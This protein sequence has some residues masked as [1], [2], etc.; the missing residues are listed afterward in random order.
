MQ[1]AVQANRAISVQSP[2]G[3]DALLLAG[4]TGREAI[5]QIFK[6]E[7]D[8]VAANNTPVPFEKLLGQKLTV[9]TALPS[10]KKRF[11][12]GIVSRM[13]E[14]ARG[15]EFT[16][17]WVEI[18]PQFWLLTK[19]FQSRI[20][21]H[22]TVPEILKQVMADLDVSFEVMGTFHPRDYTVQYRETDFDFA[23]R[24]ME[25]EGIFYFFKH[26][27]TGHKMVVAN[28]AASHPELPEQSKIFYEEILGGAR[29]EDRITE[30]ERIQEVRSSKVTLWDNCF[31]LPGQHLEADKSVQTEATV[32]KISQKLRIAANDKSEIYEYPGDYAKRFDGVDRGGTAKPNDLSLIFQDNKRTA[33][34]R[35]QQETAPGVTI[36]GTGT[37]RQMVC[38]H[39][40][41]LDRH[42]NANGQYLITSVDHTVQMSGNFRSGGGGDAKVLINFTCIPFNVPYRPQRK[43]ERPLIYGT[44]TAVVVGP[45]GQE[46]FTDEYGRVKVQFH[47]DREGKKNPDSSCWVRV[48]QLWA[49]KRWG[50]SFWPRIGQEVVVA[51][52]NGD[53]DQPIIVGSVYNAEQMPPYLGPGPDPK[54]KSDRK[55][56]GIK[57]C[58]TPGGGG[59]NE[60]RFDDTKGKEQV[61]LHAQ[62]QKDERVGGDS[63]ESVGNDRHLIVHANQLEHVLANKNLTVDGDQFEFIAGSEAKTVNVNQDL[64]VMGSKMETIDGDVGFHCYGHVYETIDSFKHVVTGDS[65]EQKVDGR[66]TVE[67]TRSIDLKAA[68]KIVLESDVCV[69]LK[70]G[71]SYVQI[72]PDGVDIFGPAVWI[73]SGGNEAASCEACGA[74]PAGDAKDADPA[75]P[76]EADG[77]VTGFPSAKDAQP[78]PASNAAAGKKDK[79]KGKGGTKEHES[80]TEIVQ[81]VGGLEPLPP[82][83]VPRQ[84]KSSEPQIPASGGI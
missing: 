53:P 19:R 10:G 44:Q 84:P 40:F 48:A 15:G 38:G 36:Q 29:A 52:E 35:M 63:L 80:P 59:F 42:H 3:K 39:R 17:Y 64:A 55:V 62:T 34:I 4:F 77:A 66:F 6:F 49:G 74:S 9:E 8:L 1:L 13:G 33:E 30:W 50:A 27:A 16:Q 45:A 72:T 22:M 60:L 69:T 28:T 11:F 54:H 43:T 78:A 14:G 67:A 76:G 12:N 70:C 46:I 23:S 65:L 18:V 20:F 71:G 83:R 56:S 73:N 51:F 32:G 25:E 61:F 79:P 81:P 37:C 21:Q 57:T 68:K 75:A 47:W 2:L 24:L 82:K 26:T 7:L 41:T 58:S 31:E 5:S